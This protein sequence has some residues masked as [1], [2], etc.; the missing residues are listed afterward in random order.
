MRSSIAPKLEGLS[1]LV[2]KWKLFLVLR[3][4]R[5]ACSTAFFPHRC[6]ILYH[7]YSAEDLRRLHE[8]SPQLSLTPSLSVAVS[9]PGL[10]QIPDTSA[11]LNFTLLTLQFQ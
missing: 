10:P 6:R 1:I 9:S 8:K 3:A 7:D 11:L 5:I 4:L 2:C